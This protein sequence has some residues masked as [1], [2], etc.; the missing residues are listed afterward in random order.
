MSLESDIKAAAAEHAERQA[1]IAVHAPAVSGANQ[2]VEIAPGIMARVLP[3][4]AWRGSGEIVNDVPCCGGKKRRVFRFLCGNPGI[5]GVVPEGVCA[6]C[7]KAAISNIQLPIPG[8]RITAVISARNEAGEVIPTCESILAGGADEICLVDDGSTD[9]SC[10]PAKLPPAVILLRNDKPAGVAAARCQGL[11]EAKRRHG[12]AHH[13]AAIFD[14]HERVE[15]DSLVEPCRVA[16]ERGAVVCLSVQGLAESERKQYGTGFGGRLVLSKDACHY[17]TPYNAAAPPQRFSPVQSAIGAGYIASFETLNRIGGWIDLPSWP[18]DEQ[19]LALACYFTDTPILVDRVCHNRHL[20]NS[21]HKFS[22]S[23]TQINLNWLCIARV[24]FEEDTFRR[25]WYPNVARACPEAAERWKALENTP[26]VREQRERFRPLKRRTDEEFARWLNDQRLL[27]F[28]SA[29]PPN[30]LVSVIMPAWNVAAFL[31]GAIRSVQRQTYANWELIIVDDASMDE[32]AAVARQ[33]AGQDKRVRLVQMREHSNCPMANNMALR[34]AKGEFIARLGA[35][36]WDE[37]TRLEKQVRFLQERPYIHSVSTRMWEHFPDGT[38]KLSSWS[39]VRASLMARREVY[40]VVKF[41]EAVDAGSD[42]C[43]E[44]EAA[45]L[46][47]QWAELPEPLYHYRIDRPGSVTMMRRKLIN[48]DAMPKA[49]FTKDGCS[50]ERIHHLRLRVPDVFQYRTALYIGASRR[51]HALV[52]TLCLTG[53]A[54]DVVEVW[55]PYLEELRALNANQRYFREIL[56]GDVRSLNR[57]IGNRRYDVV[58]W[59]H[60]P[61]HVRPEELPGALAQMERAA[62]RLAVIG[63]THGKMVNGPVDGNPANEQQWA[64]TPEAFTALGWE[65]SSTWPKPHPASH[66]VAWKRMARV[67]RNGLTPMAG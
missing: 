9:G 36:D 23:P 13:V 64:P 34:H 66:L 10:D 22:V 27:P 41:R 45:L 8:L 67:C 19:A 54:V 3:P 28:V 42:H 33:A 47:Y 12:I 37:P 50:A 5:A 25:F 58:F 56:Q 48:F 39:P 44:R 17:M 18:G 32:T 55:V 29:T 21:P 62:L 24:Y 40:Q 26:W 63:T 53:Y 1:R 52:P 4:C 46:N 38:V 49:Y 43:W 31:P 51:E 35:D 60:G 61:E 7:R 15:P 57:A 20:F 65:A 59:W 30:P 16:L 6:Q 11:A 2:T 14:A